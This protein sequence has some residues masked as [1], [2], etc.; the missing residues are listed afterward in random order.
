MMSRHVETNQM[1]DLNN[2]TYT[3]E[4]QIADQVQQKQ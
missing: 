4:L 3:Q 2:I 1:S